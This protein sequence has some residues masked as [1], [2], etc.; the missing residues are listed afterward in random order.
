MNLIKYVF[1]III[2]LNFSQNIKAQNIDITLLFG[3]SI[4]HS[5]RFLS[6]SGDISNNKYFLS[7][8]YGIGFDYLHK[9]TGF[10]LDILTTMNAN[11]LDFKGDPVLGPAK[12]SYS[13]SYRV[14]D[15]Q[16]GFN[17][18]LFDR[19]S[20]QI[21]SGSGLDVLF[22]DFNRINL[23]PIV[24]EKIY[25]NDNTIP[26]YLLSIN[27]GT[28][29]FSDISPGLTSRLL[30]S[31]K[32]YRNLQLN[33]LIKYRMGL[34]QTLQ[35]IHNYKITKDEFQYSRTAFS[36]NKGDMLLLFVG[37]TYRFSKNP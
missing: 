12:F 28:L 19:K 7:N 31:Y 35:T 8:S 26:D 25:L 5:Q 30:F 22:F 24:N 9:K 3:Q 4:N 16:L 29:G 2:I 23:E 6:G 17:F 33:L 34:E 27:S 20:M 11:I 37:I 14:I 13:A 32:V 15:A 1:Y 21:I 10:N 36:G 18:K